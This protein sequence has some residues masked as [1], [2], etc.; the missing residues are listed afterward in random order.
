MFTSIICIVA[1]LG[2]TVISTMGSLLLLAAAILAFAG[3]FSL[4]GDLFVGSSKVSAPK[5]SIPLV[6]LKAELPAY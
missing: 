4:F 2:L 1:A 6:P 5:A 3:L